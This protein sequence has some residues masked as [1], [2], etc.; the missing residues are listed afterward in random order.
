MS[1]RPWVIGI[2]EALW[3]SFPDR[4]RLGG[5]PANFVFHA[6]Q[7]GAR[8]RLVSRIGADPAG[9]RLRAQ[10]RKHRLSLRDVQRD[11]RYPTGAVVIRLQR[12]MPN[13][14]IAS[15]AAWDHLAWTAELAAL[16]AR[17]DAVC[18]GT[19]AQRHRAARSTLQ[20]FVRQ[21]TGARIKLFDINLRAG[22]C[23]RPAIEFG[24]ASATALK[25][26]EAELRQVARLF[27]WR[28]GGRSA[29]M[30]LFR[31]Y[32]L[33][34]IAV[35]RGSRGCELHT[36]SQVVRAPAPKITCRDTVGAGDAF[37]AALTIGLLRSRPL[38]EIAAW[39][40]RIAAHVASRHGAMVPV[41]ARRRAL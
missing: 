9:A 5:A 14:T 40:N 28:Q 39:A 7:L 17:A 30:R 8:A 23:G 11:V 1:S 33:D 38:P 27:R 35:T 18:F 24:L 26:N 10:L 15:P 20:R 16:A 25:L 22:H 41:P 13:Y 32:P 4:E 19:L 37:S 3:D 21:C 31:R 34:L 2:G 36:R 12:G 6:A 29:I